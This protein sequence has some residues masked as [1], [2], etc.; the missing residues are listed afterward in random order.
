MSS[1]TSIVAAARRAV[2]ARTVTHPAAIR[3]TPAPV[4]ACAW[5]GP[6]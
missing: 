1:P 3:S 6:T 4:T 2:P 5:A